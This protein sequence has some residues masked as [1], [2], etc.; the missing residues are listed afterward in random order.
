[1]ITL[2][3]FQMI[4]EVIVNGKVQNRYKKGLMPGEGVF[5]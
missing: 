3:N 5:I 1:M 4:D 2:R